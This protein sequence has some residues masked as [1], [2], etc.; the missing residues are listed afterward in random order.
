MQFVAA[1]RKFTTIRHRGNP[2]EGALGH[3]IEMSGAN[4]LGEI[5]EE[6]LV[7]LAPAVK[8]LRELHRA[9]ARANDTDAEL[10]AL[11]LP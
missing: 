11:G 2:K 1:M 8:C 6:S 5:R 10:I 9:R 7:G 4:G 3:C